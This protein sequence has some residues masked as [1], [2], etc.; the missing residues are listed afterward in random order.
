MKQRIMNVGDATG[1]LG[2]LP[3]MLPRLLTSSVPRGSLK[4]NS[5]STNLYMSITKL[6]IPHVDYNF[7]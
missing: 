5:V 4:I 3:T 2:L 1:P 7:S 6:G